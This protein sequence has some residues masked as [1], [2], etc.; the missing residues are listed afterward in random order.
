MSDANQNLRAAINLVARDLMQ[1]GRG[2][3]IGGVP[4]PSGAGS[5]AIIRPGPTGTSYTFDN[6]TLSTLTALSPARSWAR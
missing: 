3:P 4:I 5:S 1:A 6:V 2:I